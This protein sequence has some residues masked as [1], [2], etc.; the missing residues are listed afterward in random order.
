MSVTVNSLIDRVTLEELPGELKLTSRMGN[1][2][3]MPI[4]VTMILCCTAWAMVSIF[5]L[6]SEWIGYGAVPPYVIC[7]AYMLAATT[8]NRTRVQ[9]TGGGLS[10]GT[11]PIPSLGFPLNRSLRPDQVAAIFVSPCAVSNRYSATYLHYYDV[12][13]LTT[14]GDVHV[15]LSRLDSAESARQLAARIQNQ[16]GVAPIRP[17]PP[18]SALTRPVCDYQDFTNLGLPSILFPIA[19]IIAGLVILCSP[20]VRTKSKVEVLS[21]ITKLDYE[22]VSGPKRNYK[23]MICRVEYNTPIGAVRNWIDDGCPPSSKVGDHLTVYYDPTDPEKMTYLSFLMP[24]LLSLVYILPGIGFLIYMLVGRSRKKAAAMMGAPEILKQ[25][26]FRSLNPYW[27][28]RSANAKT[29]GGVLELDSQPGK[30]L[31]PLLCEDAYRAPVIDVKV[32]AKMGNNTHQ[33]AGI[34]FWADGLGQ[35][36]VFKLIPAEGAIDAWRLSNHQWERVLAYTRIPRI[37]PLNGQWNDL[38]V[39]THEDGR[40]DLYVNDN[41]AASIQGEPPPG[42]SLAGLYADFLKDS[43][44]TWNFADFRVTAPETH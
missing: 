15:L 27:D 1:G 6:P 9:V 18:L 29:E 22:T 28:L 4:A 26:T 25:D 16:L 23:M 17:A 10:W 40:A 13:V 24:E 41:Y 14:N 36:Y 32:S 35:G 34:F 11:R 8:L 30:A 42:G 43:P 44:V 21:R 2:T 39:V 12:L 20:M 37:A 33:G 31:T 5:S 7:G 19:A 3:L 38:R